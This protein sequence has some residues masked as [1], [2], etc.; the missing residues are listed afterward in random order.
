MRA[1]LALVALAASA[2]TGQQ[3]I[4]RSAVLVDPAVLE[5][6]ADGM[7]LSFGLQALK[8]FESPSSAFDQGVFFRI[9]DGGILAE[10]GAPDL[11]VIRRMA[12][13]PGTGGVSIEVL[14]EETV[15]LG[16]FRVAPFQPF[17][18][19]SGEPQPYEIDGTI[20][21][22]D[23]FFPSS[24]A[25][26]EG[27]QILRDLRVAWVRFQPVRC[28]P[29][30]GEV[31]VTTSA[32]I[33]LTFGGP[34]VNELDGPVRGTTSSFLQAY[35]DVLGWERGGTD[36]MDGS[37][38]FIS[39]Q[40]GLA[41]VQDLID[42]K[43]QRGYDVVAADVA[44]IGST[45]VEVDAW[46]EE[47]WRS[48]PNPPEWIL[49][50]GGE[51]LVPVPIYNSF[52]ADNIYGVVGQNTSVPSIHVGRI[53]GDLEDLQYQAWKVVQHESNPYQPAA[54][55]FQ[56]AVTIGS[57]DGLDPLHS[58]EHTQMFMDNG[59]ACDYYCDDPVYGGTPPSIPPIAA[60]INEG[61]SIVD[62]IGHGWEYGWGTSGFSVADVQALTNGRMLPWVLSIACSNA[63]FVGLYCYGEAWMAEGSVE[64]PMGALGF[65]G[66]TTGSPFGPT[67][68]LA[69]Y[70][71]KGY[72]DNNIWHMG[73][74][75][76]Y[77]KLKVQEFYGEGGWENNMM[78][79]VFGCPEVDID[80]DTSPLDEIGVSH[81]EFVWEGDW[82]VY[83]STPGGPVEG[84]QIGLVQGG[85]L[86][87]GARTDANGHADLSIASP[88]AGECTLTVTYH[89]C[90]PYVA[91]LLPAP[92]GAEDGPVQGGFYLERP[93]PSPFSSSTCI[94][95]GSAGAGGISVYDVSGRLVR[96]HSWTGQAGSGNSW[97]WDGRDG[98]GETLPSGLYTIRL[99]TAQGSRSRCCMLLR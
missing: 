39:T 46:I 57:A 37:Y 10:E 98:S 90:S 69:E 32:T 33:R 43:R 85:M 62:Y 93:F 21:A 70:T 18:L 56:R 61:R 88:G 58:W 20:Y 65:M 66:A 60:N 49:L 64:S 13:V 84:A 79:M 34:G 19:R 67:D 87:D 35:R 91:S 99:T 63:T 59:I 3:V 52:A 81:A 12:L 22:T 71:W 94:V 31:L 28:N 38:V 96:M 54:S 23:A 17:Q 2:S 89:N 78:H 8:S 83:V 75:V 45:A 27:V 73:A 7:T 30:T 80:Y 41:A 55:W 26:I 68:S 53:T 50:A 95:F 9:P 40:E 15:P 16:I 76:D 97:V 36:L 5:S 74:A 72:F 47:A 92:E 77:G 14:S 4:Y 11:P 29:V 42:W 86:L 82:P 6:S 44:D 48:W 51:D 1:A 24:C 25:E